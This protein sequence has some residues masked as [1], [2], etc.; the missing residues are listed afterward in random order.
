MK[1]ADAEAHRL[2][3]EAAKIANRRW[4]SRIVRH[5]Q[6]DPAEL[7]ANENNW[8]I[9]PLGQQDAVKGSLDVLGQIDEVTVNLRTSPLFG[10]QDRNVETMID[11]HLRVQL[12]LRENETL[13]DVKYVDLNPEEEK[14]ALLLKDWTTGLAVPDGDQ[15]RTLISEVNPENEAVRE[16]LELL[17][18]SAGFNDVSWAEEEDKDRDLQ[19]VSDELPGVKALKD[20]ME[21]DISACKFGFPVLRADML[22]EYPEKLVLYPGDDLYTGAESPDTSLWLTWS[23]TSRLADFERTIVGFYTDDKRFEFT[24]TT[25]ARGAARFINAGVQAV[26]APNFSLWSELSDAVHIYQIYRTRWVA[27]YWQE[28]GL[29][30][31]PDVDWG[32]PSD[33]E[34]CFEGIPKKPPVVAVQVQAGRGTAYQIKLARDGIEE[35]RRRVDPQGIIFYGVKN[36]EKLHELLGPVKIDVP[37]HALPTLM[38]IRRVHLAG[39]KSQWDK[40]E[41][42]QKEDDDAGV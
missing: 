21:F 26:V 32:R 2:R 5:G 28:A 36:E 29:K 41:K 38:D 17:A 39:K 1:K 31:I 15:V 18:R 3:I 27:R 14:L 24:W 6:V 40:R 8:R 23:C 42:I 10:P 34:F 4:R 19:E 9:H 12:A 25:P 16:T 33:W 30:V 7:L 22:A 20:A 13:I 37:Y 11:G 35:M